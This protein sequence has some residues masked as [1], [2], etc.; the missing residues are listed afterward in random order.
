MEPAP[1]H[2]SG[3]GVPETEQHIPLTPFFER[4]APHTSAKPPSPLGTAANPLALRRQS[5]ES[6]QDHSTPTQHPHQP[7]I[8]IRRLRR[9]EYRIIPTVSGPT[10]AGIG[11]DRQDTPRNLGSLNSILD[12][13]D[14]ATARPLLPTPHSN[15]FP[16]TPWTFEAEGSVHAGWNSNNEI[17]GASYALPPASTGS[18]TPVMSRLRS[19]FD[20]RNALAD[21]R[22]PVTPAPTNIERGTQSAERDMRSSSTAT[23]DDTTQSPPQC[24]VKKTYRRSKFVEHLEISAPPQY[25]D[26]GKL[27]SGYEGDDERS[28]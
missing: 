13:S 7:T 21:I 26:Q 14:Q 25:F 12:T 3:P 28:A 2:T 5:W 19:P 4:P 24:D 9:Q 15:A 27:D 17:T 22:S 16:P 23:N 8:Y 11:V 18:S 10:L 6:D 1:N 20:R